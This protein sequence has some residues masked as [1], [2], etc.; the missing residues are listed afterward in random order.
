MRRT[1]SLGNLK[2]SQ[3]ELQR[4]FARQQQERFGG[5]HIPEDEHE[6]DLEARSSMKYGNERNSL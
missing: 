6:D 4:W 5:R 3:R 2:Q 1:I